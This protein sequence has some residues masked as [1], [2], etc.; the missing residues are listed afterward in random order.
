MTPPPAIVK[1]RLRFQI[2]KR[3]RLE[4]EPAYFAA[5]K[6]D[7]IKEGNLILPPSMFVQKLSK[8]EMQR[9][10]RRE[11]LPKL[12]WMQFERLQ[13]LQWYARR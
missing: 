3:K 11:K 7:G 5:V 8:I 4:L 10:Y 9:L 13:H 1:L 6:G 12:T 2:A